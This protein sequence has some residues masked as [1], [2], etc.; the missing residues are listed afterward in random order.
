M[1]WR[2]DARA[3]NVI[4]RVGIV[5]NDVE[6]AWWLSKCNQEVKRRHLMKDEHTY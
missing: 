2:E 5:P 6:P 3:L 1:L 4:N